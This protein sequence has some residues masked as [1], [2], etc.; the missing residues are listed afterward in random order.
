MAH[1]PLVLTSSRISSEITIFNCIWHISLF[2]YLHVKV[3][4]RS[5]MVSSARYNSS[6]VKQTCTQ[7]VV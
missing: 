5:I 7:R 1:L 3:P 2:I 6:E 4:V